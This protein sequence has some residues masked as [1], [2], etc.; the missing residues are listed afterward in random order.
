MSIVVA[1]AALLALFVVLKLVGKLLKFMLI[2]VLLAAGA[3]Y[4][5]M[6]HSPTS[7]EAGQ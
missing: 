7:Q 1:I 2:L 4:V 6:N 3:G 5:A